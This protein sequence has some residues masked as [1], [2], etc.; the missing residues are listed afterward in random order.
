MGNTAVLVQ[1]K[2]PLVND[3]RIAGIVEQTRRYPRLREGGGR[4]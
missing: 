4:N 1:A 2:C 3:F